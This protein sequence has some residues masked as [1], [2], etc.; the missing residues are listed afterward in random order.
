[1]KTLVEKMKLHEDDVD[2]ERP[3]SKAKPSKPK[4]KA[5]SRPKINMQSIRFEALNHKDEDTDE[6]DK[7]A[8]DEE[9]GLLPIR[10]AAFDG[11][12]QVSFRVLGWVLE[13][14]CWAL[15]I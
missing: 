11:I 12:D 4:P 5:K 1:L 13:E 6:E 9:L 8:R 15:R 7:R 3:I 2:F 10:A 14:D